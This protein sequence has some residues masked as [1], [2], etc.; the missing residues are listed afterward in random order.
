MRR[1]GNDKNNK[2]TNKRMRNWKDQQPFDAV[3]IPDRFDSSK[4]LR[5]FLNRF[6]P[7]SSSQA[8]TVLSGDTDVITTGLDIL[9][10]IRGHPGSVAGSARKSKTHTFQNLDPSERGQPSFFVIT[11]SGSRQYF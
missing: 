6:Y 5:T 10:E 3:V 7:P 2:T 4:A 8:F 9:N 1:E 11:W